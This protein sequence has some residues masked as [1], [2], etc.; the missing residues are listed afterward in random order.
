MAGY[1]PTTGG[2]DDGQRTS[3][4]ARAVGFVL[5]AGAGLAGLATVA[6][7]PEYAALAAL[8]G[9]RDALSHQIKCERRLA[10][11][12]QRKIDAFRTD[13]D[14]TADVMIRH[15]NYRPAGAREVTAPGAA[16]LSFPQ[17]L[18]REAR[19]T[20]PPR[21]AAL[22]QARLW[23]DDAFTQ[24]AVLVLSLGMIAAGVILFGPR[25]PRR[26]R[27]LTEQAS[28]ASWPSAGNPPLPYQ[29]PGQGRSRLP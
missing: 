16:E 5:F 9:R 24:I 23:M 12:Y 25:V 4:L 27:R 26:G 7:L 17:R 2:T 18:M 1:R 13:P 22:T 3:P 15:G 8:E 20:P 6:A 10:H 21:A 29:S 14:L 11:Y 19:T 28:A